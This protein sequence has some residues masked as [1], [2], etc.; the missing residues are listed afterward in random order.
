MHNK[1][2]PRIVH[3]LVVSFVGSK[4][5]I[6]AIGKPLD[7]CMG[8]R[9]HYD[10]L[11]ST[12]NH[13]MASAGLPGCLRNFLAPIPAL[14][15]GRNVVYAINIIHALLAITAKTNMRIKREGSAYFWRF[16]DMKCP[17]CGRTEMTDVE[18]RSYDDLLQVFLEGARVGIDEIWPGREM[19]WKDIEKG[20]LIQEICLESVE[21][22]TGKGL[23]RTAAKLEAADESGTDGKRTRLQ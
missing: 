21:V 9:Y 12:I 10:N 16:K 20:F 22:E 11:S 8:I 13:L 17:V 15:C 2:G 18:S 23:K 19:T 6:R 1:Y 5:G 7:L 4:A 3:K 14:P